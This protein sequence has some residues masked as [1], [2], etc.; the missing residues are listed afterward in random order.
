MIRLVALRHPVMFF[1][2]VH[3]F[4]KRFCFVIE[5][6]S[7]FEAFFFQVESKWIPV[8]TR[9]PA[10]C[11][12]MFAVC[13]LKRSVFCVLKRRRISCDFVEFEYWDAVEL[14]WRSWEW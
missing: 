11:P 2:K 9:F 14:L 8:D 13:L 1:V 5:F 6:G 3:S 7:G 10:R 4:E 12:Y